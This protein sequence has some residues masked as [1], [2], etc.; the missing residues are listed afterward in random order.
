MID[1]NWTPNSWTQK[2]FR[3]IPDYN[4][5]QALATAKERLAQ[6]PPLVTSWEV[7]SLKKKLAKAARGE[8]FL[9]Q[10]GDC[11][12]SFDDCRPERI[13]NQIKVLLQMSLVLIHEIRL[14]V[15]R[16]ARLA[17]QYA[18]PR[19]NMTES[20]NGEEMPV[21]RGDIFNDFQANHKGREA[22]AN[23]LLQAYYNASMTLNFIRALTEGGGFADLHNP[24][25]WKLDFMQNNPFVEEYQQIV[26]SIS[27]AIEFVEMVSPDKLV[28]LKRVHFYTSHEALNL[29]YDAAQTRQVPHRKGWYNLTAHT[30]WLGNRTRDLNEGHVEYFRGIANPIGIKVGPPFETDEVLRLLDVVN[31]EREEGKVTL[32]TRM[33]KSRVEEQLPSLLH[34][35]TESG[36][37]VL[38]I[39]DPMH[40]N[41]YATD[42]GIKTRDFQDILSEV[43]ETFAIHKAENTVLGGIH[44]ELTGENVT[45]CVGGANGLNADRLSQNYQSLCDPRL[46]YEQSMEMAFLIAREYKRAFPELVNR[47]KGS[48]EA[49]V[50]N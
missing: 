29:H 2:P 49:L 25:F 36:H 6:F 31:P 48:L 34:K 22:D 10:G 21:Y 20:I 38:W 40:G 43:K 47:H 30:V 12:E 44:L 39:S 33:G 1:K 7:E 16:V 11:A 3:Q 27:N 23:R 45:E 15:V 19:S 32:V 35:V 14:P 24:E 5:P 46:N 9:L 42:G 41:T 28:T 17:G 13:V 18:K 37:P 26:D 8:S 50:A 4:D